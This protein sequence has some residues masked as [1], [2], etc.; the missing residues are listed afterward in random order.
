MAQQEAE[1]VR[2]SVGLLALGLCLGLVLGMALAPRSGADVRRMVVQY[3]Q[4]AG[5]V[6]G[7]VSPPR[8]ELAE[9]LSF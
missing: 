7:V 6:L 3:V 9:D 4:G 5:Q 1:Q 8:E 2:G